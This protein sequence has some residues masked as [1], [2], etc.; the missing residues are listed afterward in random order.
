MQ[1]FVEERLDVGFDYGAVG[2][3]EWSTDIVVFGSG[4]EHRNA[5]WTDARGRWE[6]GSRNIGLSDLDYLQAFFRARRGMAQGFRYRDWNDWEAL[7]ESLS[8]DGT[9]TLQL[10]KTYTNAGENQ[11]REIR[12]PVGSTVTLQRNVSPF[13][14]YSLDDTTGIVTLVADWTAAIE[15]ITQAN[16]AVVTITGHGRSTGDIIYLADIEGM[17]ELNDAAYTITVIDVDNFSLDG[18]DST[19]FSAYT[20]GGTAAKYVQP[21][22]TLTWS[23]EFDVPV[24]FDTDAF[25]ARFEAYRETPKEA[26]YFLAS[27]PVVEIRL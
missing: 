6:L 8:P 23:G 2:G 3:P 1:A 17:T 9:P 11:V 20:N 21:S 10:V 4:H 22:E 25:R 5:N 24:R 16:P 27:L 19:G 14:D 18:V 15:N 12:K 13:V 26:I 7:N